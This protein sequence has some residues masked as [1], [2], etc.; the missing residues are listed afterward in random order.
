M[1]DVGEEE[2]WRQARHTVERLQTSVGVFPSDR[3]LEIGCGIGRVGMA[4]APLVS[5][6][7][8]VD[9]S[10]T[11]LREAAVRLQDQPNV[12]LLENNGFDL[13]GLSASACDLAYCTVVF[14]HLEEWDR[15]RYVEEAFRVLAPGGR[16]YADNFS[17]AHPHGWQIFLEHARIPPADRP[18]HISKS[19][20]PEE[21][22]IYFARAGF[23]NIQQREC[24]P[25]IETWG[26]RLE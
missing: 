5:T 24:G 20:T 17:L 6:W 2:V 18:P 15:F 16:F 11:M 13:A 14:M 7:T 8:G 12:T 26:T 19:S 10:P 9:V 23:Q 1:G 22:R 25:W 4:L 21:L 3:A